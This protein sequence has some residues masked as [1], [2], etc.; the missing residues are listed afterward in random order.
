M[1]KKLAI[2]VI[3]FV[4]AKPIYDVAMKFINDK[5]Y[6]EDVLPVTVPANEKNSSFDVTNPI[7]TTQEAKLPKNV[8]SMEELTDAFFYYFSHFETDFTIHYKGSTSDIGNILTRATQEATARDG[9]IGGHLGA[10][11]MEYEYGKLDATIQVSQDYLT[12][13]AQEQ[14]VEQAVASI[15]A[16]VKPAT[17]TDFEKVKFVNDYIVKNTVYSEATVTSA[18]SAFTILQEQK[19]VCQGYALLALKLLQALGM[20]ALYITGEVYTGGH[21]WNL[22]KVDGDWYHL[23]TT[24][25][26]PVPDRGQGVRYEYFLANDTQM[27]QDHAWVATDFPKATSN[28]YGFMHVVQDS[29]EKGGYVYYSN[30]QKDNVL[31]RLNMQTG[32]NVRLTSSRALFI[33]G[34]GD[35]LYFSNYSNGAYLAKIRLD[36][37]EEQTLYREEVEGLF[38]EDGVLYFTTSDGLKKMEI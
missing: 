15:V 30:I 24:W 31:Y 25:N 26:D 16:S 35:W 13:A 38:I 2:L 33:T 1:L 11:E 14:V 6:I 37:T 22:V 5:A 32:E 28:N 12:N 4:F 17:M 20:E 3:L 29:Y 10:R 34:Y 23:D 27:K 7:S 9:Y 36:G 8:T 18:H 19:G 21:A